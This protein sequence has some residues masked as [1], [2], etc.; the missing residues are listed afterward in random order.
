MKYL[1]K[2]TKK[3]LQ[4]SSPIKFIVVSIIVFSSLNYADDE[5]DDQKKKDAND[6]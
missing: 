2:L 5:V 3:H 1:S 4:K 6:R